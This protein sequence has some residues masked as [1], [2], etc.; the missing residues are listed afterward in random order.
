[1]T[2]V[3]NEN[4]LIDIPVTWKVIEDKENI[5]P[6]AKDS[7]IELAVIS[8]KTVN[9]FANN[10]LILSSELNSFTTSSD[11]SMFNNI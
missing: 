11:F 6:V 8:E 5:L 4:L 2:R 1:L 10:L 9:G 7:E 3:E